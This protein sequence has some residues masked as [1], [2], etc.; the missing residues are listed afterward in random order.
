M[1]GSQPPAGLTRRPEQRPG[2]G[3]RAKR[4]SGRRTT[5]TARCSLA[6]GRGVA[7]V[8]PVPRHHSDPASNL[9]E[10]RRWCSGRGSPGGSPLDTVDT[11]A[12][13]GRAWLPSL[14]LACATASPTPDHAPGIRGSGACKACQGTATSPGPMLPVGRPRPAS[15]TGGAS[16]DIVRLPRHGVSVLARATRPGDSAA[17]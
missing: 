3:R 16:G 2:G 8:F 6:S 1:R 11:S 17:T 4:V 15:I 10:S 14:T 9:E 12:R 13:G 5:K 7:R